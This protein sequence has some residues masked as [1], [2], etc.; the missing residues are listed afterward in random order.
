MK[1]ICKILILLGIFTSCLKIEKKFPKYYLAVSCQNAK[2]CFKIK[3]VSVRKEP[4]LKLKPQSVLLNRKNVKVILERDKLKSI[5]LMAKDYPISL[6]YHVFDQ[7][8]ILTQTPT[9]ASRSSVVFYGQNNRLDS[10]F[11]LCKKLDKRCSQKRFENFQ[12]AIT[13]EKNMKAAQIEAAKKHPKV[14]ES[15][16]WLP[17]NDNVEVYKEPN[18]SKRLNNMNVKNISLIQKFDHKTKKFVHKNKFILFNFGWIQRS[19]I[20]PMNVAHPQSILRSKYAGLLKNKK[21]AFKNK[22]QQKDRK[23]LTLYL[24]SMIR[25]HKV[26]LKAIQKSKFKKGRD[27]INKAVQEHKCNNRR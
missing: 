1:A 17:V 7:D 9:Q 6:F 15:Y 26:S 22:R 13:R 14:M 10:N 3:D 4:L 25:S 11:S 27:L 2:E 19:D 24:D 12:A 16:L 8:I 20:L 5:T 18:S 23:N 21:C